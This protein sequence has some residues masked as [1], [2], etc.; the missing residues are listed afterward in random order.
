MCKGNLLCKSDAKSKVLNDFPPNKLFHCFC[1]S[2]S[3]QIPCVPMLRSGSL[4]TPLGFCCFLNAVYHYHDIKEFKI[5]LLK[6]VMPVKWITSTAAYHLDRWKRCSN[7]LEMKLRWAL[8]QAP[9]VESADVSSRSYGPV[10]VRFRIKST[11]GPNIMR[12]QTSNPVGQSAREG[13]DSHRI[14]CLF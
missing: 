7:W 2:D 6:Y 9:P 11:I 14:T 13:L 8:I 5:F 3:T 4:Q 10:N 1:F 12:F